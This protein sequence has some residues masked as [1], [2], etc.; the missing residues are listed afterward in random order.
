MINFVLTKLH[1]FNLT[2]DTDAT[3]AR[4]FPVDMDIRQSKMW[5]KYTRRV[6]PMISG[7]TMSR[8]SSVLR[9]RCCARVDADC[10]QL[11]MLN[12]R[13]SRMRRTV[14]NGVIPAAGSARSQCSKCCSI[15]VNAKLCTSG[16]F[17]LRDNII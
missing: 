16:S 5:R 9:D 1:K 7:Q 4:L 14:I 13:L 2:T 6:C 12:A 3:K 8:Q 15:L 10:C 11:L 17:H